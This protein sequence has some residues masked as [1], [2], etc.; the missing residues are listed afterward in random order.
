MFPEG[1]RHVQWGGKRTLWV[2]LLA[3]P[4]GK[5]APYTTLSNLQ[6]ADSAASFVGVVRLEAGC[7]WRQ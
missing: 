7:P 4:L 2:Q 5:S 6:N 3:S 1:A